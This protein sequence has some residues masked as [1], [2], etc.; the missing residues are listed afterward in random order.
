MNAKLVVVILLFVVAVGGAVTFALYEG[1]VEYR[2]IPQLIS[3]DYDG[4]RV[5]VKAQVLSVSSELKPTVF[6]A[7]DILTEGA[8]LTT[9]TPTCRVIYEG[10]DPPSGLKKAA[11]V[12]MEGRFDRERNA[13][14]ATSL[15]T[16]CPSRYEG[17]ELKPL[18]EPASDNPSP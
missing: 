16:Q 17:E 7:S 10:D 4:E 9:S 8:K 15:Q 5:K 14:V 12:T 3:A 2:T 1:G 13:F 18:D 6:V 11:H